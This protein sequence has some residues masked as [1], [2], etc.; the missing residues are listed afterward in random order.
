MIV[1]LAGG[2]LLDPTR[3]PVERREDLW[4]E[5]GRIVAAPT[6]GRAAD[7]AYDAKDCLVMAGAIDIHS[8]IVGGKVNL[9]RLLSATDHRDHAHA[10]SAPGFRA[11][12]GLATPSTYTT[13]WPRTRARRIWR[14]RTCRSS[15]GAPT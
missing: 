13:W 3:S 5:N 6:D 12:S 8:H 10:A 7:R 11:G 1:R 2:R 4:I 15:T 9:G 14:W